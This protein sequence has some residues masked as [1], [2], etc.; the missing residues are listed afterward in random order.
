[1]YLF[2]ESVFTRNL[3]ELAAAYQPFF[4][5]FTVCYSVKTN[6]SLNILNTARLNGVKAEVVSGYEYDLT[7]M[8][9]FK[10]SDIVFDGVGNEIVDKYHVAESGGIVNVENLTQLKAMADMAEVNKK[11]I[12]VGLRIK[13]D[14]LEHT[15]RFGFVFNG[16]EYLEA[17]QIASQSEY[18]SINGVHSHVP[19]DRGINDWIVRVN[20]TA[21]AAIDLD[22]SY[23]DLGS[24]FYGKMDD[25]LADQFNCHIPSF[26][27]YAAAT[28]NTMKNIFGENM[29]AVIV[30]PGT[31]VIANAVS[32]LCKV[33]A[34]RKSDDG[35]Y[36]IVD[37]SSFDCGYLRDSAYRIPIARYK[38][39]YEEKDVSSAS[40]CGYVCAESDYIEKECV[41]GKIAEGDLIEVKNVGAY[42][43]SFSSDFIHPSLKTY[44]IN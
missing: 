9:G 10:P 4:D 6:P 23:V 1:M 44:T 41:D 33:N 18:L 7:L 5:R 26:K 20:E 31:P 8:A 3:D 16:N 11:H 19:C 35:D 34:I 24:R 25:E 36:V 39:G 27:E 43:K 2:Y 17:K 29:P 21:K 32:M 22:A 38:N 37:G 40:I 15:S 12:N 14:L 30:E 13:L 42:G 28:Y